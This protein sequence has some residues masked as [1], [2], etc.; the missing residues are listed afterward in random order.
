MKTHIS[1]TDGR[2][3]AEVEPGEWDDLTVAERTLF[4]QDGGLT[5]VSHFEAASAHTFDWLFHSDGKCECSAKT[6]PAESLGSANGYEHLADAREIQANGEIE[7]AFHLNGRTLTLRVQPAEEQRCF[8]C[9][10]PGNP[11]DHRRTTVLLRAH[12]AKA[13]FRVHYTETN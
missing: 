4:A 8:L 1:L 13:E 10:S 11:A 3:K 9:T 2:M 12:G 6:I 7:I 5:D